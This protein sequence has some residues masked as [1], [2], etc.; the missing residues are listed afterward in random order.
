MAGYRRHPRSAPDTARLLKGMEILECDLVRSVKF[1]T[2]LD[3]LVHCAAKSLL[4]ARMQ[5]FSSNESSPRQ[6]F[7][8]AL[9][10]VHRASSSSSISP[11]GTILVDEVFPDTEIERR[12]W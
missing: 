11:F 3:A 1:S 5:R 2:G 12:T 9:E 7:E 10:L 6:V 4:G 8:A